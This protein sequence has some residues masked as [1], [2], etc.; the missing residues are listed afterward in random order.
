MVNKVDTIDTEF[1]VFK[2]EVIAGDEDFN[3]ELVRSEKASLTRIQLL[4]SWV[5]RI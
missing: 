1:R 3:V 4:M 5:A 2:M